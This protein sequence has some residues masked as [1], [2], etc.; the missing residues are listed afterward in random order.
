[1]LRG[2]L[3]LKHKWNYTSAPP[4]HLPS[5]HAQGLYNYLSIFFVKAKT[6]PKSIMLLQR[7]VPGCDTR[8]PGV[9]RCLHVTSN[10]AHIDLTSRQQGRSHFL[11]FVL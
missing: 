11:L 9:P 4:L 1:M 3:L 8:G 5:L 2:F 7:G 10:M 6:D